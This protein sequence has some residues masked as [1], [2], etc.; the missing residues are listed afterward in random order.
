[1]LNVQFLFKPFQRGLDSTVWSFWGLLLNCTVLYRELFLVFT[2]IDINEVD[3]NKKKRKSCHYNTVQFHS[4]TNYSLKCPHSQLLCERVT[5]TLSPSWSRIYCISFI[6]VYLINWQ[7]S[8]HPCALWLVTFKIS[9]TLFS[10]NLNRQQTSV[11]FHSAHFYTLFYKLSHLCSN[12]KTDI[13]YQQ[14][15]TFTKKKKEKYINLICSCTAELFLWLNAEEG[16]LSIRHK[17]LTAL[18]GWP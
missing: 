3:K 14:F 13:N 11:D 9:W 17:V 1:M 15:P 7:Q 5:L 4:I 6:K 16:R 2:L 12:P 10:H 18:L 8:I